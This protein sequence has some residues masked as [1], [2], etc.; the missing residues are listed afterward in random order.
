MSLIGLGFGIWISS[1]STKYRDIK[2]AL[3][4]FVQL[5]MYA[6]PIIYPISMIPEKYRILIL[7]NPMA[8]VIEIFRLGYLGTGTININHILMSIVITFFVLLSGIIIFNKMEK[9]F[10]DIV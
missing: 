2:F 9:T 8:P 4:F 3:P 10:I 5:W 6:T 7:L 1:I